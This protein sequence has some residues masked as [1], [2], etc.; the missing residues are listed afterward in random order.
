MPVIIK[1]REETEITHHFWRQ[2]LAD[3][4]FIF[5][6]AH[7]E[8]QRFQPVGTGNIRKPVFIFIRGRLTNTFDILEHGKAERIGVNS[9]IPGAIIG[10]LKYDIGMA[11]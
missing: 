8:V 11:V 9:A 5:K 7:G 1:Y 10:R 4:A 2:E 3:K 6:I